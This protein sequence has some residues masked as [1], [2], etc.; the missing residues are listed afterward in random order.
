MIVFVNGGASSLCTSVFY[1]RKSC[2][3]AKI[4]DNFLNDLVKLCVK[5]LTISQVQCTMFN[6]VT[7]FNAFIAYMNIYVKRLY[8]FSY[9]ILNVF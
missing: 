1:I 2:G 3:R 4:R 8:V 9:L 7:T 5:Y 6:K